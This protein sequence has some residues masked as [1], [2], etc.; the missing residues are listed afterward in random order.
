MC[1]INENIVINTKSNGKDMFSY[2]KYNKIFYSYLG[3]RLYL[4]LGLA[5]VVS[6]LDG[7]GIMALIPIFLQDEGDSSGYL[8]EMNLDTFQILILLI[9]IFIFKGFTVFLMHRTNGVNRAKISI[10]IK[11]KIL[12]LL[13]NVRSKSDALT[14]YDVSSMVSEHSHRFAQ[15]LYFYLQSLASI[16][17]ILGY[18]LLAAYVDFEVVIAMFLLG[19][20]LI[21]IFKKQ[22]KIVRSSAS[23]NAALT[24]EISNR[25]TEMY[26]GLEY[27]IS[28]G[29][30]KFISSL[31]EENLYSAKQFQIKM[32]NSIALI[33][34]IKE[35]ILI[36]LIMCYLYII[37]QGFTVSFTDSLVTLALLYRASNYLFTFQTNK[38]AFHDNAASIDHIQK[39]IDNTPLPNKTS[40]FLLH[41]D[42]KEILTVSLDNISFSYPDAKEDVF[43]NLKLN[44]NKGDWIAITGKSGA[45]KSSLLKIILG[46]YVPNNGNIKVNDQYING[47]KLDNYRCSIG[48]LPQVPLIFSGT[49]KQNI[50]LSQKKNVDGLIIKLLSIAG[51]KKYANK[52]NLEKIISNDSSGFSGGE[53]QRICLIRELI[54]EP[55][56]LI[57]D[58]GTSGLDNT[59]ELLILNMI[60]SVKENCIIIFV[61]HKESSLCYVDKIYELS[62]GNILEKIS[63][64]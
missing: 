62:N 17:A 41:N 64:K 42:K 56:L 57:I 58:E 5:L 7:V 45:G 33:N 21:P 53:L 47:S 31:I 3:Y 25:F 59:N 13:E 51:L 29:Q 20:I 26:R 35:P 19:I 48:Y 8:K 44:L 10:G 15:S 18:I 2:K 37:S 46:E 27:L 38:Q 63:D 16:F 1:Q 55:G 43:S 6:I 52:T 40:S 34:A 61:S 28:T 54:R 4:G 24:S 39:F 36:V 49:L 30:R 12:F 9:L 23:Q 22:S 32:T 60:K 50:N 14:S 11:S